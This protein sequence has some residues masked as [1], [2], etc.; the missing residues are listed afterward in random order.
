MR[1]L[2]VSFCLQ[3]GHLCCAFIAAMMHALQNMWPHLVVTSS[4]NGP[5]QTGQLK[6]GSFGGGGGGGGG[7]GATYCALP[8]CKYKNQKQN[9]K[10][11]IAYHRCS[12]FKQKNIL[13]VHAVAYS[14][15]S[16]LKL[17]TY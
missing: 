3:V 17:F 12:K 4:T 15:G 2:F 9:S 13:N 8:L 16:S 6:V 14:G 1:P 7:G 10:T 5:I 11:P